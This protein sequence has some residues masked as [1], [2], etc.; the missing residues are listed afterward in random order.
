MGWGFSPS[1]PF[2]FALLLSSSTPKPSLRSNPHQNKKIR[3]SLSLSEINFRLTFLHFYNLKKLKN[4]LYFEEP[5]N[6]F[7]RFL[8][9]FVFD[10]IH[11]PWVC[12]RGFFHFL[13][14]RKIFPCLPCKVLR[15]TKGREHNPI[16]CSPHNKK[17]KIFVQ[18]IINEVE[19]FLVGKD[20]V[21]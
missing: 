21:Q 9:I 16:L 18:W 1:L 11:H 12:E 10:N 7:S 14:E 13:Q 2:F 6:Y 17:Y 15:S 4:K 8:F 3:S 5:L 20:Q 19:F